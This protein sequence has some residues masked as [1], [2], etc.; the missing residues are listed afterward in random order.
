MKSVNSPCRSCKESGL[1]IFLDLGDTPL[2]DRLLTSEQLEMS[3]P[4]YPLEVA[5]CPRC[6]LVQI[7]KTVAPELLFCDDYP[8]F[9]SFSPT[10]LSHSRENVLDLIESYDLHRN[11]MVVELASNDGYLLK[12]YVEKGIPCHR[13]IRSDGKIGG[14]ASGIRRKRELLRKEGLHY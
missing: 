2:A 13:V 6:G 12:N 14:F 9:S 11:S 3:E 7:L 10:L 5:F 4:H 1:E 8:Y